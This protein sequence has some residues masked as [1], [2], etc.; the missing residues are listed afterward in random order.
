M[1]QIRSPMPPQGKLTLSRFSV[2]SVSI[3][4]RHN[5]ATQDI[6]HHA[7]TQHDKKMIVKTM[8]MIH[9]VL[10]EESVADMYSFQKVNPTVA[11]VA[12]TTMKKSHKQEQT[13]IKSSFRFFSINV[14]M[15]NVC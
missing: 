11:P 15:M 10:L 13:M 12:A 5:Q 7:A 14:G 4:L 6:Q 2:E 1:Q 8:R 3:S 9:S